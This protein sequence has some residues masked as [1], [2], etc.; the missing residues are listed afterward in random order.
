[1]S[2]QEQ[3]QVAIA[4]TQGRRRAWCKA[5]LQQQLRRCS[6]AEKES[7]RF[8]GCLERGGKKKI[9]SVSKAE[10]TEPS[11]PVAS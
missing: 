11:H 6:R 7:V 4:E 9:C 3:P 10:L 8:T 2:P 5:A 1:M